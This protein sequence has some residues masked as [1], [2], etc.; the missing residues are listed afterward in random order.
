[1]RANEENKSF[2]FLYLT[3]VMAFHRILVTEQNTKIIQTPTQICLNVECVCIVLNWVI[4]YNF[5]FSSNAKFIWMRNE[6]VFVNQIRRSECQNDHIEQRRN[7]NILDKCM[8]IAGIQTY[9]F[10]L[11]YTPAFRFE[12]NALQS[13]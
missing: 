3:N 8:P 9:F 2:I 7:L 12:F 11:I 13:R 1:M 10:F 5:Q 6:S 4:L